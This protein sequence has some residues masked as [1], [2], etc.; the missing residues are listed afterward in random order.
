MGRSCV[1]SN[2]CARL[3]ASAN[4]ATPG[5]NPRGRCC[6]CVLAPLP[7]PYGRKRSDSRHAPRCTPRQ[8]FRHHPSAG[9][10]A[11]RL[12]PGAPSPLITSKR[13]LCFLFWFPSVCLSRAPRRPPTASP[14]F[15][16]S[17]LQT[18][19]LPRTALLACLEFT[20]V[21]ESRCCS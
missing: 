1:H 4:E 13:S 19:A 11:P 6:C 7:L 18:E 12:H 5:T 9:A 3:S 14:S 10:A 16:S 20:Y 2:I 8:G 15:F 21:N 17:C